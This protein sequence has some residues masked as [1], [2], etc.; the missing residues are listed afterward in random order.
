MEALVEGDNLVTATTDSLAERA[1]KSKRAQN[2]QSEF[3]VR[4]LAVEAARLSIHII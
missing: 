4:E 3:R 2:R 1:A